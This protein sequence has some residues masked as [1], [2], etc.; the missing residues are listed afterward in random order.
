MHLSGLVSRVFLEDRQRI[1]E[2][3]TRTGHAALLHYMLQQIKQFRSLGEDF[4]MQHAYSKDLREVE[5]ELV[6]QL[7]ESVPAERR[8]RG[9]PAEERLRGLSLEE[10]LA[11]LSPE[12]AARLRELLERQQRP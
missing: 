11:G 2:E 1:I 6:T 10:R 9:L 8:V 7:L 3:L 4:A 5:E 12:D